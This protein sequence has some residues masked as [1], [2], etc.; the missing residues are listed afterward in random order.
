MRHQPQHLI[1]IQRADRDNGGAQQDQKGSGK[2]GAQTHAQA[3]PRASLSRC[4]FLSFIALKPIV[5]GL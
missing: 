5:E 2:F 4:G 3:P 1:Q